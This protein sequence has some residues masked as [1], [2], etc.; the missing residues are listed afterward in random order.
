MR[1]PII[2]LTDFGQQDPYAGAMKGVILQRVDV[3]LVDL[4][5][6]IPPHDIRRAALTLWQ[7]YR[8]FPRGSV[9]LVVVDPGVGTRRLPVLVETQGYRFVAPDNGVLT[10]VLDDKARAWALV[11]P[12]FHLP[13]PSTTFHGRDIFAPAAAYAAMGVP[14]KAFGPIVPTLQRIPLP[15][16]RWGSAGLEGETL[17]AD[18]FGNVVTSLGVLRRQTEGDWA[19][20]SWPRPGKMYT[21]QPRAVRLPRHDMLLPLVQTFADV[22]PDSAAALVGS[23]GLIEIVANG[24]SAARMLDLQPGEPVL[25][26]S[27][28]RWLG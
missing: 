10:Y 4:T 22:P 20:E 26:L 11:N 12:S 2:L 3:P 13:E 19:L 24:A 7:S 8:Y 9:F 28:K 14:G 6:D 16:W 5:H 23:S 21:L 27:R 18:R 1:T 15:R 17:Y 25:L